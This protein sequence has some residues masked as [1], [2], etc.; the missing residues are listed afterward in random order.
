M[1]WDLSSTK[2]KPAIPII[3]SKR[4][5]KWKAW[6]YLCYHKLKKIH[7]SRTQMNLYQKLW[8]P[9]TFFPWFS[10][11]AL[12]SLKNNFQ[13]WSMA[14]I[15]LTLTDDSSLCRD[16]VLLIYLT[17][18]CSVLKPTI[19]QTKFSRTYVL[20]LPLSFGWYPSNNSTG[21]FPSS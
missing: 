2:S 12:V 7:P 1:W 15:P 6:H 20:P 13:P 3:R 9:R 4:K 14:Y 19:L 17:W 11:I 5:Q 16:L 21:I 10:K 8:N 18:L